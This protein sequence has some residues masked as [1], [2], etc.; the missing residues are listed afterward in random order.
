M[1]KS[2]T[3][4]LVN[5]KCL[6]VNDWRKSGLVGLVT[7]AAF[8]LLPCSGLAQSAYRQS[9]LVSDIPGLAAV[10]DTNLVNPWG[11]A[12][13]S[14][15]PFWVADN[16]TGLSTLYNS[17][18]AIQSL[19]VTIPPPAGGT[20]AAAPTGTIFNGTADF[21]VTS[22][23]SNAPAKFIFATED[24]TISGWASGATAVLKVDNSAAGTV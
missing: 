14:G 20:N 22:G 17:T 18:G 24:G 15:S 16:H 23:T 2:Y 1:K 5:T 4:W 9:N 11:I 12:T 6:V 13:S 7:V 21:V 10:T 8:G 19:V 3:Y